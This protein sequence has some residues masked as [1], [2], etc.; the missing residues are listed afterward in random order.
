M[1]NAYFVFP[2]IGKCKFCIDKG[3]SGDF[4]IRQFKNYLIKLEKQ[5]NVTPMDKSI[6]LY[7]TNIIKILQEYTNEEFFLS[8]KLYGEKN[9]LNGMGIHFQL[10]ES[11]IRLTRQEEKGGISWL[12]KIYHTFLGADELMRYN[13]YSRNFSLNFLIPLFSVYASCYGFFCIHGSCIHIH[14]K[15]ILLTGLDGVGKSTLAS[16]LCEN[17]GEILA[18]NIVLFDGTNALNF[19]LAMRVD[20][21]LETKYKMLYS[22]RDFKEILP[23]KTDAGAVKVDAVYNLIKI[24]KTQAM[25]MERYHGDM[26]SWILYMN[27]A[28]EINQINAVISPWRFYHNLVFKESN[29]RNELDI[30]NFYIPE[31]KLSDAKEELLKW[32]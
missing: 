7:N 5:E 17:D 9:F 2:L 10:S 21:H 25:K 31:G 16:L 8:R 13:N 24:K 19:N 12:K 4:L 3:G 26:T 18:D 15:N 32:V 22:G 20:P 23:N 29:C 27:G 28:P 14:R 1:I 30:C 6:E 11:R